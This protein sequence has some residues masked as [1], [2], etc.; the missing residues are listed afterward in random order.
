[1]AFKYVLDTHPLVWY[2]E[3]NPRL[4]PKVKAVIDDPKSNLV[5][6]IIALAEATFIVERGRIWIGAYRLVSRSLG[7]DAFASGRFSRLYGILALIFLAG[8]RW[9][10]P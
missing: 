10:H 2:L 6:P 1:M 3:G 9:F 8:F 7:F 4:S 5:L